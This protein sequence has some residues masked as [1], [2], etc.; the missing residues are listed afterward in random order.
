MRIL[1]IYILAVMLFIALP[2]LSQEDENAETKGKEGKTDEQAGAEQKKDEAP[3]EKKEESDK[4]SDDAQKAQKEL[5]AATAEP[6]KQP[7]QPVQEAPVVK[8][9]QPVEEKKPEPQ[10]QQAPENTDLKAEAK[11]EGAIGDEN[12]SDEEKKKLEKKYNLTL[13]NVLSHNI[14]KERK[15]FGESV[16]LTA[17]S[18]AIPWEI[19]IGATIGFAYNLR[20]DLPREA[21]DQNA[22]KDYDGTIN[23]YKADGVPLTVAITRN[24]VLPGAINITP[25]IDWIL[26]VTSRYLWEQFGMRSTLVGALSLSRAFKLAD[27]TTLSATYSFSY[28]INFV[29][30][31]VFWDEIQLLPI[32]KLVQHSLSNFFEIMFAYA[33]F[34]VKVSAAYTNELL[35]N[36][37]RTETAVK[38][39]LWNNSLEFKASA[40]YKFKDFIFGVGVTTAGPEREYGGFGADR[41]YPFKDRYSKVSASV[42]YNYSF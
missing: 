10:V 35:F 2:L 7:E 14:A 21:Y 41:M 27:K 29:K 5:D 38:Y 3:V 9:E 8:V 31:G 4:V 25:E 22:Q 39:Q 17:S 34:S 12:K 26:P 32:D 37:S 40:G 33:D 15:S 6:Q 13:I 30:E 16:M 11:A 24:F 36:P 18:S 28:G 19:G 20:Y 1:R 42:G 23:S